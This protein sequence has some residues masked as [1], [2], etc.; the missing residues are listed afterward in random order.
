M[1]NKKKWVPGHNCQFNLAKGGLLTILPTVDFT[2]S[3]YIRTF[4]M[5]RLHAKWKKIKQ[6]VAVNRFWD[7]PTLTEIA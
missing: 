1:M 4:D 3:D 7:I 5:V 6:P 2:V